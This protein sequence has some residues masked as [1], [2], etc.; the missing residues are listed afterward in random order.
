[1]RA[2]VPG[3]RHAVGDSCLAVRL[4]VRVDEAAP[5][6]TEL[7]QDARD[8]APAEGDAVGVRLELDPRGRPLVLT[9]HVLDADDDHRIRGGGLTQ[10]RRGA[11]HQPNFAELSLPVHPLRRGRAGD[12]HLSGDVRDRTG[13][14]PFHQPTAT[15]DRQ[16]RVGM[17]HPLTTWD[18]AISSAIA[19]WKSS[20][21]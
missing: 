8:R 15:L 4:A 2:A 6:E 3:A 9:A 20:R 14:T 16:R 12:T 17:D 7:Q 11:I 18:R 1:M 13:S 21:R 10:R 19:A 5:V